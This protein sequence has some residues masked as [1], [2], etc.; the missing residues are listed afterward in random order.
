MASMS[1]SISGALA[2]AGVSPR[3]VSVILAVIV[4]VGL[5][6]RICYVLARWFVRYV[7][8]IK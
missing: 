6:A 4:V 1:Q 7:I 8:G 2:R 3:K 5:F